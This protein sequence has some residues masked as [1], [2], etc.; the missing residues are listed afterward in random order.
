[1]RNSVQ[2]LPEKSVNLPPDP[3]HAPPAAFSYNIP[4][5]D[6]MLPSYDTAIKPSNLAQVNLHYN[7]YQVQYR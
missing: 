6:D 5:S 7:H 3:Y 2:T 4:P 1:M